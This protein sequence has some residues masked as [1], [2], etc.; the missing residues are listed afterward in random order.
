MLSLRRFR[1]I[2]WAK[3]KFGCGAKISHEISPRLR[4]ETPTSGQVQVQHST[5][6]TQ[7]E[8]AP[9]S[10]RASGYSEDDEDD[11]S[12]AEYEDGVEQ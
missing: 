6:P 3:R 2:V 7:R 9:I 12:E 10:R 8:M 1:R 11:Y 4:L 5:A